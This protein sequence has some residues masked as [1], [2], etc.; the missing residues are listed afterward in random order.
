MSIRNTTLGRIA[1]LTLV[2]GTGAAVAAVAIPP[3][4]AA[5][6]ACGANCTT[7]YVQRWGSG[8][9][10]AVALGTAKVGQAVIL[11]PAGQ[12]F[13]EDFRLDYQGTVA[14]LY[15][16]GIIGP[17]VGQTWPQDGVYEYDYAPN[18]S[19]TGLCLGTA[20]TAA[21]GT[22]VTL[23]PCGTSSKVLWIPLAA[24]NIGGYEPM[25]AGSDTVT[26][27]PYVLTAGKPGQGLSTQ[28]LYLVAGTFA[29][30]QMWKNLPGVL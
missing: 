11:S 1:T 12:Y 22:A 3:V 27:T 16:A 2:C 20:T 14:L 10:S 29:P 18:G 4:N 15:N 7:L 26:A 8:N 19:P 25:I 21:N 28:E 6:A 24:D 9:V 23:Q 13:W 17:A 30:L 5:T